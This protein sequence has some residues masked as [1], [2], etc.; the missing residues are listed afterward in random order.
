M[1]SFLKSHIWPIACIGSMVLALV[2]GAV[3]TLLE[4]T[5]VL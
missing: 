4:F 1:A 5:G 3:Y 2:W